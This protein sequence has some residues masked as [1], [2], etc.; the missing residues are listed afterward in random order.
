MSRL[1]AFSVGEELTWM[2][3]TM[4]SSRVYGLK[5]EAGVMRNFF[6]VMLENEGSG[7]M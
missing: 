2:L 1:S 6:C 4:V 5:A 7:V 3:P